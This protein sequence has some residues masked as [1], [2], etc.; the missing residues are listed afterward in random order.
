M[1]DQD[2]TELIRLEDTDLIVA[3]KDA[4]VRGRTAVDRNGEEVGEIDGLFID[5]EERK[6]RFLELASGGLLGIG[7]K[8]SLIPVAAVARVSE[9]EVV[10]D[11]E[12]TRIAGAPAYDP[13]LTELPDRDFF[14]GVYG[15]YGYRSHWVPGYCYPRFP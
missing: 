4:D 15:Y 3:E 6:V 5:T 8:K 11:Q 10:I 1:P 2:K 13:E 14:E 7:Q 12:R 9:D